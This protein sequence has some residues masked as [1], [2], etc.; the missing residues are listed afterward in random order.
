MILRGFKQAISIEICKCKSVFCFPVLLI[1]FIH[2]L[3]RLASVTVQ[4][5]KKSIFSSI[6]LHL[7]AVYTLA[8]FKKLKSPPQQIVGNLTLITKSLK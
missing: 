8:P 7:A 2:S 3:S 6:R 5:V 1:Y 4:N